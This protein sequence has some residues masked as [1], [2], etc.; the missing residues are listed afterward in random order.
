MKNQHIFR[1][2]KRLEMELV[3]GERVI[4]KKE[5]SNTAGLTDQIDDS[6][7]CGCREVWEKN[8]LTEEGSVLRV[9]F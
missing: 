3:P 4:R 5:E 6:T 1:R 7:N 9:S 8:R 2:N